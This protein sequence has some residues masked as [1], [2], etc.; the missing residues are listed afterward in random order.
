MKKSGE[1]RRDGMSTV[2]VLV[3]LAAAV[4]AAV[5]KLYRDKKNGISLQCGMKC[6]ECGRCAGCRSAEDGGRK[7]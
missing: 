2:I 5:R 6:E 3:I 7:E 1:E 4:G